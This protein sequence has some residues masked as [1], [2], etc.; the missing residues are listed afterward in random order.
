ML[1]DPAE[2]PMG[3]ETDGERNGPE[4]AEPPRPGLILLAA[5]EDVVCVD[6]TCLP[7]D[8]QR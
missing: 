1:N 8:V 7:G 5:D 2:R 6:D 3:A 4:P